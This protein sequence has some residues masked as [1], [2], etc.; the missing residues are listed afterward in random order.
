MTGYRQLAE[1]LDGV[2]NERGKLA[3]IGRLAETLGR[4]GGEELPVAA[5]LLAG[6]PFAEWEQT[7]TSVGWRP[8]KARVKSG[9]STTST[10]WARA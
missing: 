5:R 3:K 8:G 2:A 9:S 1:T 4:L 7:V 10:R 6:S